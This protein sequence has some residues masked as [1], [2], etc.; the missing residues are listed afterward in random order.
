MGSRSGCTTGKPTASTS[1]PASSMAA[2]CSPT[3]WPSGA[4]LAEQDRQATLL[5][6]R[7]RMAREIHDTL[8]Q[9]FTGI[10]L[11]LQAAEKALAC[12]PDRALPSLQRALNLAKESLAEARRS[13]WALRPGLLE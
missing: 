3:S 7:N 13:V 2:L 9:G 5:A 8:A 6:E 12:A 4:R 1:A 11:Q 10:V